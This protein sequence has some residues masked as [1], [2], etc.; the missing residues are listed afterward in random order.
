MQMLYSS[1]TCFSVSSLQ[2]TI[3][4]RNNPDCPA[5]TFLQTH[6]AYTFTTLNNE[7]H[8]DHHEHQFDWFA[9]SG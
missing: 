7:H 5:D 4:L 2:F 3:P 9:N 1:S 8:D 6:E